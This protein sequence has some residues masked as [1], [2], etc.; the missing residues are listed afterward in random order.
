M[1]KAAVD[2]DLFRAEVQGKYT[3]VTER[4]PVP[5]EWADLITPN[6]IDTFGGASGE[7]KARKYGTNGY[8]IRARKP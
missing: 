6:G 8:P 1:T 5:A 7:D 4:L 2:V 3:E